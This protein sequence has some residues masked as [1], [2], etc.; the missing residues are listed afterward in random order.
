M[1][2]LFPFS[3]TAVAKFSWDNEQDGHQQPDETW[4]GKE[5]GC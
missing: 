3:V 5:I 4:D 1:Y 2:F